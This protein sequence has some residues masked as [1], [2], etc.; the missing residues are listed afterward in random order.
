[1]E[2]YK[3]NKQKALVLKRYDEFLAQWGVPYN[4]AD[5]PGLWGTTHCIETGISTNPPLFLFHGVGDN[6]AV[7]WVLNIAE[8]SKYFFCIALDTPGGPG[9][10]TI[11]KDYEKGFNQED[12]ITSTIDHYSFSKVFIAGVSNGA[13]MAY[14]Y[15][16]HHSERV[17]RIVCIEGGFTVNPIKSMIST[18]GLLFPEILFPVKKNMMKIFY[19]LTSPD[20][21]CFNEH[22]D[23]ADYMIDIMKSHN[24]KAMF[25]HKL[26]KFTSHEADS[27]KKDILFLFGDFN[28]EKRTDYFRL[29]DN[30]LMSY[31]II[32]N[33]GHALNMERHDL[34]NERIIR[35]LK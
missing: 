22:P 14:N 29:L 33:A 17:N 3:T 19:K 28:K 24:Q 6:S 13:Y 25:A 31:S 32:P 5:I 18:L 21:Q 8:L 16:V 27:V 7:M 1:M 26:N 30:E 34:V 4:E 12:W 2:V 10:S 11:N 9:K 15:F 35:F 23:I 20:S